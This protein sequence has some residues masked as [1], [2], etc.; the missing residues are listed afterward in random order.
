MIDLYL[1]LSPFVEWMAR[2]LPMVLFFGLFFLSFSPLII[3]V[4]V[5]A[6]WLLM[7]VFV[8]LM[9]PVDK[10]AARR[11]CEW[12]IS[13]NIVDEQNR[14]ELEKVG[15]Y[16]ANYN[17]WLVATAGFAMFMARWKWYSDKSV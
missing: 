16:L 12:I 4:S 3:G 7:F 14:G 1:W 8:L 11:G 15:R 13:H 17:L 2:F 10:D 9:R 5:L 6:F